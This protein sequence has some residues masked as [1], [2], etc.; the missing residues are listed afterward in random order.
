MSTRLTAHANSWLLALILTVIAPL[1]TLQASDDI[2]IYQVPPSADELSDAMFPIQYRSVVL[3]NG[4]TTAPAPKVVGMLI[5]FEFDSTEVR[6]ESIPFLE[7]VGTMLTRPGLESESILIEGHTDASGDSSY[8][9]SLSLR[10]AGAIRDYLVGVFA[11]DP[12]RLVIDG[13][14]EAE[15]FNPDDPEHAINRRVQFKPLAQSN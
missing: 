7:S 12:A 4:K 14:G 13:K 10:R 11:I 15:P 6:P 8:N 2:L 1:Q 3:K 5:N 9:A